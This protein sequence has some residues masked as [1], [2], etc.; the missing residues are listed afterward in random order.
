M[1]NIGHK[2]CFLLWQIFAT[3]TNFK[4]NFDFLTANSTNFEMFLQKN[5]NFLKPQSVFKN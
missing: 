3:V 4:E 1:L 2:N 5:A